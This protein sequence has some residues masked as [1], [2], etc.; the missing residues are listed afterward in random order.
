[1][2]AGFAN[3]YGSDVLRASSAGLAPTDHIPLPTVITMHERNIDV[4][5]HVPSL[6]NPRRV[7][8][9]DLVVNMSGVKLP[10]PPPNRLIEWDV[11]DPYGTSPTVYRMVRD[12]LEQRVMRLILELRAAVRADSVS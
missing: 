4:S 1:M 10:G 11:V 3:H 12:Q 9:F 5:P 8:K 7:A 6:Y 2:A